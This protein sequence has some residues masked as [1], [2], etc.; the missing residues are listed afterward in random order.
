MCL[1]DELK[2]NLEWLEC[3]QNTIRKAGISWKKNY[4]SHPKCGMGIWIL[5]SWGVLW[6][7]IK[8]SLKQVF[9]GLPRC[10]VLLVDLMIY[11]I[12]V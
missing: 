2:Q 5:G 4:Q 10:P 9:N 11:I 3:S 7:V 8:K 6:G 1:C 12:K